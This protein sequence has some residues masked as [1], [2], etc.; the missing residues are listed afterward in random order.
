MTHLSNILTR[1][2][3]NE[4]F[5]RVILK[6]ISDDMQSFYILPEGGA[7]AHAVKGC[8]EIVNDISA[9]FDFILC[10]CGTGATLAGIE[11]T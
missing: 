6:D 5:L 1:Q 9:E 2:K 4:K 3:K 11:W 8:A 7:N 10:A